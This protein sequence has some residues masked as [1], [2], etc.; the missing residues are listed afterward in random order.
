M[1][2]SCRTSELVKSHTAAAPD[3]AAAQTATPR[4]AIVPL[5]DSKESLHEE[6]VFSIAI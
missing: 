1:N 3:S 6:G 5:Q 2:E 4:P